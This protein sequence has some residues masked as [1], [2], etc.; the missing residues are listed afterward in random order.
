MMDWTDRH[1]R[2]FHRQLSPSARLFSEMVTTGAI[3]H[4]DKPRHLDFN[5]AEHPVVLQLGGGDPEALA[6][7][8]EIAQQWGYDEVNLNV[9][10]P[11]GR[12]Q[13]NKIGACLMLEPE[14]V[15]QCVASMIASVD[16]PVSVK[17]RLGVDE[18]DSYE[19]LHRFVETV[20]RSGCSRFIVHA[21]KALLQGLSPKANREIPSLKYEWV[22]QLKQD[23]PELDVT[24]NGGIRDLESVRDHL[25]LVDGV[26]IGRAAYQSPW[27][28]VECERLL[29]DTTF[30]PDRESVVQQM[31]QY[32][33]NNPNVALKHIS[34][35][36]LGL[37]S[38]LPGARAWRRFISENAH[39][40]GADSSVL[41]DAMQM[42]QQR[43]G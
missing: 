40:R 27:L 43:P 18:H 9:G 12:V 38:G 15:Q 24:I 23:M 41:F 33:D 7:S 28:L 35:H 21:R 1:C 31:V 36:M 10:C 6:Q 14:L 8:S 3:I 16:I 11:S 39:V 26:M 20:A 13:K 30:H 42:M 19:D 2:Y 37:F 29:F 25:E 5:A 17:C 4:G 32:A 34:R 22:Y